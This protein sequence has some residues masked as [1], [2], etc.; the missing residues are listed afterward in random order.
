MSFLNNFS[1][2]RKKNKN[3]T[4]SFYL[5]VK[6]LKINKKIC[7][8]RNSSGQIVIRRKGGGVK[9]NYRIIDLNRNLLFFWNIPAMVLSIEYDPNR[10]NFISL[11]L[12]GNGFYSYILHVKDLKIGQ[13]IL[14]NSFSKYIG[15]RYP[16]INALIN[17]KYCQILYYCRA[18]G[19][20][21]KFL[22]LN[23]KEEAILLLPSGKKIIINS[24]IL[25][26]FGEN[27]NENFYQKFLYKAGQSRHL[28][29]RPKVRGVAM[30]PVDHPHGGG[31]GKTSG[32]RVSVT[33][34]GVY[35]K[36]FKRVKNG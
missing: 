30:N 23:S 11:I 35:T 25:A 5:K 28:N 17:K 31:Q 7:S 36:G 9:Q 22:G 15:N 32:G 19:T 4:K 1:K 27:S 33:P 13:I 16:L 10:N 29:K 12:Y 18:A 3:I 34:W 21:I 8:G 2:Y 20:F 14:T 24:N 26:T 6:K